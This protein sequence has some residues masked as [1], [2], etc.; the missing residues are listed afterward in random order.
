MSVALLDRDWVHKRIDANV[1][2]GEPARIGPDD[3]STH[4]FFPTNHEFYNDCLSGLSASGYL[5]EVARQVNLAISHL[6]YE[7]PLNAGF[8][9]T[10]IDWQFADDAPFVVTDLS[11][12]TLLT[13]VEHITLRKGVI[14]K[15]ETRTRFLRGEREFLTGGA[16]FL[17]SSRSLTTG[18]DGGHSELH[19]SGRPRAA[20][21]DAQV[22]EPRNVLIEVPS[23]SERKAGRIPMLVDPR[24]EFFFEHDNG[25]VPGMML[26]EAGKQAAVY[27]A[28]SAFPIVT[29]MYGDFE[30]GQMRFGRFADLSRT[31]WMNC[32][33]ASL[34]ETRA[35]YQAAVEIAFEQGEREIGRIAGVLSFLDRR[36]VVQASAI[37]RH[38][39]EAPLSVRAAGSH[40]RKPL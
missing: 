18:S 16:A 11:A 20:P 32:R 9:V 28:S 21:S 13:H 7:V 4:S 26:L 38:S 30:A 12:F 35:G 37:L 27:A 39:S 17:I 40:S 22:N 25:H 34:A 5:I 6:C 24:H 19:A 23:D 14:C 15:V 29:G 31:V 3:F 36:E 8:L 1:F 2:I 10:A 33:F